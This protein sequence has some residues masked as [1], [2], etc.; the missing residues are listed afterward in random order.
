MAVYELDPGAEQLMPCTLLP[1]LLAS[2]GCR[3]P[4][5]NAV[6]RW[7]RTGVRGVPLPTLL[8]GGRR[9]SSESAVRWWLRVTSAPA[10]EGQAAPYHPPGAGACTASQRAA[11]QRAGIL[12]GAA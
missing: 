10:G 9:Y 8:I 11:L 4:H 2:W 5:K 3:R 1:K 6:T 12:E 7:C